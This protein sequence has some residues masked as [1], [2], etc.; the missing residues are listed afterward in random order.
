MSA[1]TKME[2]ELRRQSTRQPGSFRRTS[3]RAEC[4]LPPTTSFRGEYSEQRR[5]DHRRAGARLGTTEHAFNPEEVA[6]ILELLGFTATGTSFAL[7]D[8]ALPQRYDDR[9]RG[10]GSHVLRDDAGERSLQCSAGMPWRWTLVAWRTRNDRERRNVP[11]D[12]PDGNRAD[13]A[14]S[15]GH[16]ARRFRFAGRRRR[17]DQHRQHGR[18]SLFQCRLLHAGR[19]GRNVSASFSVPY[20][21]NTDMLRASVAGASGLITGRE[22]TIRARGRSETCKPRGV[23]S[24]TKGRNECYRSTP[25]PGKRDRQKELAI[26]HDSTP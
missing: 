7:N 16:Y 4:T 10:K 14:L 18:A 11:V 15:C 26:V 13:G 12:R 19:H 20:A 3:T 17:H 23:V 25:S 2:S 22:Q 8:S 1:A 6:I 21:G 24:K 5:A 9:P